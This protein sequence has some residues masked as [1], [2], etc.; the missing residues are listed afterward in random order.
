[1]RKALKILHTVAAAGLIGGLGAYV[2]LLLAHPQGT[3]GAYADLRQVLGAVGNFLLIPSLGIALVTGLVSMA[4]HGP[5]VNQ[6]WAWLKAGLGILMFRGVL[7]LVGSMADYAAVVARRIADGEAERRVLDAALAHEWSVLGMVMALSVANVVLGVWRPRF[8]MSA[9]RRAGLA[10][11]PAPGP[12]AEHQA[13][14][15]GVRVRRAA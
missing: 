10:A 11:E 15:T 7:M 13:V 9:H 14:G 3:P 4:V 5:F 8:A 1:M 2:V 6:G 12:A